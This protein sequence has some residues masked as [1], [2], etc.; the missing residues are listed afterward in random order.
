MGDMGYG[1]MNQFVP[2]LL[3][4]NVL[5]GSTGPP[6]YDPTFSTI[7]SYMFGAHYFFELFD[8]VKYATVPKAGYGKLFPTSPGETLFTSFDQT[9]GAPGHGPVW[10]LRMGVVNDPARVSVLTVAQP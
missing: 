8:P 1:R 2:Q 10:T 3:L 9:S 6:N 4:G 5:S 7:S